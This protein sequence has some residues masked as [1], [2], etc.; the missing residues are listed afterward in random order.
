MTSIFEAIDAASATV[1]Y[2]AVGALL[3]AFAILERVKGP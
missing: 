3:V 2:A 1:T